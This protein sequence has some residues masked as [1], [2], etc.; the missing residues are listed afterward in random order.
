MTITTE[1]SLDVRPKTGPPAWMPP[2]ISDK[3]VQLRM[4][5]GNAQLTYLASGI[6]EGS[7]ATRITAGRH[8]T[9]R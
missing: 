2:G 9:C 8:S 1:T 6:T 5:A 3:A 4:F 7:V